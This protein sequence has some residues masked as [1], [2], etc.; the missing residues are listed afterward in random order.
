MKTNQL[1]VLN[2][3]NEMAKEKDKTQMKI[4]DLYVLNLLWEMASAMLNHKVDN[5]FY[6][7]YMEK[8]LNWLI[9]NRE[10]IVNDVVNNYDKLEFDFRAKYYN[11]LNQWDKTELKSAVEK[12]I[13]ECE[14]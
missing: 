5:E 1:Y 3:I 4:K 10:K 8:D 14:L 7:Y 9:D 11:Y 12:I 13:E 6:D 2:L